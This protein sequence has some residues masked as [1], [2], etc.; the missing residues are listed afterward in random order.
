MNIL[1]TSSDSDS[2]E[3]CSDVEFVGSYHISV[4]EPKSTTTVLVDVQ[5][6]TINPS[7]ST[8]ESRKLSNTIHPDLY[9]AF[10]TAA[11]V[12]ESFLGRHQVPLEQGWPA[13]SDGK[14][15][16]SWTNKTLSFVY[17]ISQWF[18]TQLFIHISSERTAAA[19]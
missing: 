4:A 6:A 9:G 17:S 2:D 12:T 16:A 3:D 7:V 15:E 8:I 18:I 11:A 1:T 10:T 13:W 5:D 14:S 19:Q